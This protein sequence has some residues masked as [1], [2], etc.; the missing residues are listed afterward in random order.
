MISTVA[1]SESTTEDVNENS[2]EPSNDDSD[3]IP[4]SYILRFAL[5]KL[6]NEWQNVNS[7]NEANDSGSSNDDE[8]A[9]Q[10]KKTFK[11]SLPPNY[12]DYY[13]TDL[14]KRM[15]PKLE[16]KLNSVEGPMPFHI[17]TV[18]VDGQTFTGSCKFSKVIK[19]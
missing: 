13:P 7:C 5:Y 12:E 14:L 1:R 10:C 2:V 17:A 16:Y 18:D 8:K 9:D 6:M 3:R 4:W 11:K 15:R 19:C